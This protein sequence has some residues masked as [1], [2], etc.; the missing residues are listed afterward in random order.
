MKSQEHI[1]K[2]LEGFG[3]A[4]PENSSVVKGVMQTIESTAVSPNLS[5]RR[6]IIMKSLIGIA[7]SVTVFAVLWWGILGDRNS[8][9]AQVMEAVHKART[10]HTIQYAQ[11]K[12]GAQPIKASEAW[13][14]RGVGFRQEGFGFIHIGNEEYLWTFAKDRKMATR[15]TSNGIDK[16]TAPIFAEIDKIAQELR[17]EYERYPEGDQ[18]IDGQPCNAYLLTKLD[19]YTDSSLKSGERRLLLYLDQQSRLV[20]GV[21]QQ[22]EDNHYNTESFVS[23]KYDESI[24]P[25]LFKPDFGKDVKIVDADKAFDEFVD[26]KKAIYTEERDGLIFAIH[27]IERFEN[28]GV[29]YVSSVR[30][31][32]ETL[33]KY[34]LT[35]RRVRPGQFLADGPA[36]NH[37]NLASATHQGI[38]VGWWA[39][40]PHMTKPNHFEVAPGR[41]KIHVFVMPHG[42]F[43]NLFRDKSGVGYDLTWDI[44]VNVPRPEAI[45]TIEEIAKGVYADLV[46]LKAIRFKYLEFSDKDHN[47]QKSAEIDDIS[48]DE[49]AKKTVRNVKWEYEHDINSQIDE[50]FEPKKQQEIRKFMGDRVAIA[51]MYNPEVSDTTLERV[52][53]RDSVTELY[54]QG[55]RITDDGLKQI[56][57]LKNLQKLHFEETSITDAGLKHLTGLS[58]LKQVYLTDTKVTADGV[59]MLKR[60]IPGIKIEWKEKDRD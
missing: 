45:P 11:P 56:S 60:A 21:V 27:R 55:T 48:S 57:G 13:Y 58:N 16:A 41:I 18:K 33:K 1:E 4:W 35:M 14:E 51:L 28:G 54:L 38:D 23:Y 12:D 19:R 47:E 44:E 17:N 42:E 5:K 6:R 22:R 31:T 53:K 39:I 25:A 29:M 34:P 24:D 20:R 10:F 36:T 15:S 37:G 9:Y 26:L 52:A 43:A 2:L 50:K 46:T 49:Y 40:I 7:A 3:K 59:E 32:E 8:L 30:G